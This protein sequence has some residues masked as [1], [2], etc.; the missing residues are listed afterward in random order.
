MRRRCHHHLI[1]LLIR[2]DANVAARQVA[3]PNDRA[4]FAENNGALD[5][6]SFIPAEPRFYG[7]KVGAKF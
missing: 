2:I 4:I 7:I 1:R 6:P 3:S 5:I